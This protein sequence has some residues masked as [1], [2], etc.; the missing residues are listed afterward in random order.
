MKLR[1]DSNGGSRNSHG[2][3]GHRL[4]VRVC[5]DWKHVTAAMWDF[6]ICRSDGIA[7]FYLAR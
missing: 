2:A 1:L 3:I 7:L 6:Q 4:R 5:V